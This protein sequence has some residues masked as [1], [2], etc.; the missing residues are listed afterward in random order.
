ML[1]A[2]ECSKSKKDNFRDVFRSYNIERHKDE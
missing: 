1:E 2:S